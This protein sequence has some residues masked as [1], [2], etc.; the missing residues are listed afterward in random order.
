MDR[1]QITLL[2]QYTVEG[3]TALFW[4]GLRCAPCRA[5]C[6]NG[7]PLRRRESAPL[8]PLHGIDLVLHVP[9]LE[10]LGGFQGTHGQTP[11]YGYCT[12]C[13]KVVKYA[14]VRCRPSSSPTLGSQP[15][16]RLA[17]VIS[18]W[19]CVGSSFGRG[20]QHVGREAVLGQQAEEG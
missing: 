15:R 7:G 13:S 4:A 9:A 5:R 6:N 19:R 1:E 12:A 20:H 14:T 10:G 18:G 11:L 2:S 3:T 8:R 17:S 16:V